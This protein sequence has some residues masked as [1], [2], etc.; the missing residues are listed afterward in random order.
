[1][2]FSFLL[3][4]GQQHQHKYLRKTFFISTAQRW[5]ASLL[6]A[7]SLPRSSLTLHS[8]NTHY[9]LQRIQAGSRNG[10]FL[11]S[12]LSTIFIL[13]KSQEQDFKSKQTV[14][15]DFNFNAPSKCSQFR[16]S[17]VN[18]IYKKMDPYEQI[19]GLDL[20]KNLS[21]IILGHW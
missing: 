12:F 3:I 15:S 19:L 4:K 8:A 11:N 20:P 10:C 13:D 21:N 2:T 9:N 17:R 5:S 14:C 7:S 6:S 18:F 1:M 16:A